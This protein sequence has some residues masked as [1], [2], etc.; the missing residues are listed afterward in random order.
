ML[1][2]YRCGRVRC[3]TGTRAV[4]GMNC[5]HRRLDSLALQLTHRL[6]DETDGSIVLG[7]GVKGCQSEDVHQV[8]RLTLTNDW[9]PTLKG[10]GYEI[11]AAEAIP[12]VIQTQ[13]ASGP[14]STGVPL[15]VH[16]IAVG[17]FL[18]ARTWV[19]TRCQ[20][21]R[22]HITGGLHSAGHARHSDCGTGSV[23][24]R[25]DFLLRGWSGRPEFASLICVDFRDDGEP[26]QIG[27]MGIVVEPDCGDLLAIMHPQPLQFVNHS[28]LGGGVIV[29]SVGELCTDSV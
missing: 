13:T 5:N 26:A 19:G 23:K 1:P 29:A 17:Q 25:Q 21:G 16:E 27:P 7:R 18:P 24:L 8:A 6:R 10:N 11:G 22:I 28:I 9:S 20:V 14:F 2:P 15:E 4:H 12:N 3:G